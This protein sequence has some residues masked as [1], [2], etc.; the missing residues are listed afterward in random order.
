MKVNSH[1]DWS[2]LREVIVGT[3]IGTNVPELDRSFF[4]FH[5]PDDEDIPKHRVGPVARS[6]VD[7]AEEDIAEFIRV[8]REFDVVVQRPSQEQHSNQFASP[9][10]T[11]SGYSALMPRDSLVVIGGEIIEAPMVC[12]SRYFETLAYKKLLVDYFKSGARWVA[13]PRPRLLDSE[14]DLRDKDC[15]KLYENEPIFDAANILRCGRD[16]FYNVSNSGNLLG[17][18]WLRS[19]LG[20]GYR[21]HDVRVCFDHIDTT[22]IPLRPGTLLVNPERVSDANIP[23][24]FTKWKVITAPEPTPIQ[25]FSLAY[26]YATDWIGLNVF[27]IDEGT[28][29]VPDDQIHLIRML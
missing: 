18:A 11:S 26:P 17:S 27:S 24:Q 15:P 16:I 9:D 14:F 28:I 8:L 6:I 2:R 23:S 1:N 12:R 20:D 25:P 4:A 22:L 29:V 7:E 13:A 21:V 19:H 3:A 5:W 10:W